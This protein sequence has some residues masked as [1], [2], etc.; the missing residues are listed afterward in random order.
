MAMDH[1]TRQE[2]GLHIPAVRGVIADARH[3]ATMSGCLPKS[4]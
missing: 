4:S 1:I 2:W 3:P